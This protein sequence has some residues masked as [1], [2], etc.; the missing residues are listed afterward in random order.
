MKLPVK[1]P[2]AIVLLCLLLC[3]FVSAHAAGDDKNWKPVDPSDLAL[4]TPKVEKDAD[5]EAIFWE[6]KVDDSKSDELGLKHY[7][8]VKVFTERGR[9]KYSKVEIPFLKGTKI[10]DVAAR[11]IKPDGTI[12]EINKSDIFENTIA[13][14][15]GFKVKQ[16]SFAVPG[17]EPGVI[18]EYRYKAVIDDAGAS[19]M[20]LIF[21][22]DIP[23]QNIT[24]YV[25]PFE[26][27][28]STMRHKEYNFTDLSFEKDKDGYFR[29]TKLNVPSYKE[30]PNMPPEDMVRYWTLLTYSSLFS[31]DLW[32]RLNYGL[33]EAY[34]DRMKPNDEIKKLIPQIIGSASTPEEKINKIFDFCRKEIKNLSF[35]YTMTA[36]QKK[37]IKNNK[38]AGDTLKQ[39][40]GYGIDI[41]HL[42][43]AMAKAAGFDVRIALTGDRSEFFFTPQDTHQRFIHPAC[44]AVKIGDKWQY[45]NPGSQYIERGM[46]AWQ[47]EDQNA[48]L[49]GEGNYAWGM[50][51]ISGPEKSLEKRKAKFTLLDDGTLEGDITIEYTGHLAHAKRNANDEDSQTQR[52]DNLKEMVKKKISAAEFSDI[53]VENVQNPEKPFVYQYKVRVPNYAS[54]VG[55]R[56]ILQP[57]FFEFGAN[58]VFTSATRTHS[59]YFRYPWSEEDHIEIVLPQGYALDNAD[60]PA[61]IGDSGKISSLNVKMFFDSEKNTLRYERKF[62]FGG[63]GNILFPAN[64]YQAVKGLFD[65]FHE[66]NKHAIT[67]KQK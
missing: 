39:K 61:P 37:A 56:I 43:A 29:A 17:L 4:K 6:V 42:F 16:V 52:E 64:S 62:Y 20:Q 41:E 18:F 22:R 14:A 31:G 7:I 47:E 27:S 57:N 54:K 45:Y 24:Y 3:S 8:R 46:L 55:K 15:S 12:V 50:T 44:I 53:K 66:A 1:S 36:D 13:N 59:I 38:N 63:G 5:A 32:S 40:M 11:V 25:K 10:K 60:S 19:G 48:L 28:F 67:L 34:K 49:V 35:D 30:E 9:E 23:V 58:P 33:Y 51:P 2:T 65:R 26:G 21:Q